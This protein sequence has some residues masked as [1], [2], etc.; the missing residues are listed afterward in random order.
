MAMINDL[1]YPEYRWRNLFKAGGVAGIVM[2]VIMLAQVVVFILWPPPQTVEGFFNLF[3]Q[4]KLLGLLSMDLLYL[5]NNALLIV[6]YLALFAALKKESQ[7]AMLVALALGLVGIAA[8]YASNTA[9]EM[10][11]LSSQYAAATSNAQLFLLL[12]AGEAM[13][14][15]YKGTAFDVYYVLNAIALLM[16]ASVMLR[17]KFFGRGI[18]WVGLISGI[19]MTIPST[20][21]TIGLIF[22]LA[23]LLPW[24]IFLIL[25]IPKLFR[26]AACMINT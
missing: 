11:S 23:S 22:S 17:S 2:L 16:M 12:G 8:Y 21:G 15:T 6:I 9:F 3:Q 24:A 7:S 18:A 14:V 25:L 10:L 26:L 1:E 20:A 13:L 4:N 19:L 5:L